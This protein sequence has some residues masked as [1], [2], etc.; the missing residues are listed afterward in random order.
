MGLTSTQRA[1]CVPPISYEKTVLFRIFTIEPRE[2]T[3]GCWP[4]MVKCISP[5][6]TTKRVCVSGCR[7]R[8]NF[9]LGAAELYV[10]SCSG[11]LMICSLQLFL[12]LYFAFSSESFQS[13][14]I[15][16]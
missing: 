1:F 13:G 8:G 16:A 7:R 6:I 14:R 15:G 2:A 11:S 10:A 12:P 3:T 5:A 4:S 9:V